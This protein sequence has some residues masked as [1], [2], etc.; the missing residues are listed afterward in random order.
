MAVLITLT[1]VCN[2]VDAR[3]QLITELLHAHSEKRLYLSHLCIKQGL[4][5]KPQRWFLKSNEEVE[6]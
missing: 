3:I 1:D 4:S 5:Q 2:F 6:R